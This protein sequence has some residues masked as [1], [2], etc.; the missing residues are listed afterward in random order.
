MKSLSQPVTIDYVHR[1]QGL[2]GHFAR[3]RIKFSPSPVGSGFSYMCT[4][5]VGG[6]HVPVEWLANVEQGLRVVIG[7]ESIHAEL[8]DTAFH[9]VDSNANAFELAAIGCAEELVSRG[10]AEPF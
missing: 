1:R 10:T 4:A 6:D 8:I 3:V 9:D 7:N 5:K 2:T